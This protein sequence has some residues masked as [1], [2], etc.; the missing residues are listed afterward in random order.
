MKIASL[1]A[2]GALG[3]SGLAVAAPGAAAAEAAPASVQQAATTTAA[4]APPCRYAAYRNA[5]AASCHTR[6]AGTR[7]AALVKCSN[8]RWYRGVIRRQ[9]RGFSNVSVAV[10][11]SGRV[12]IGQGVRLYA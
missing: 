4:A 6:A 1:I 10:C 8:G 2:A 7:Y 12:R 9:T 11:P 5:F 3:L